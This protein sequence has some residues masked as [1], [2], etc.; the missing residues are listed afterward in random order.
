MNKNLNFLK[1]DIQMTSKSMNTYLTSL[2]FEKTNI[3]TTMNC[4]C[5]PYQKGQ[6]KKTENTK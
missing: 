5:T 6:I 2:I 3:K 4:Y 1:A